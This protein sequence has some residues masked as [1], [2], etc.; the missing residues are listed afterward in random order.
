MKSILHPGQLILATLSQYIV[1]TGHPPTPGV[2]IAFKHST[3]NVLDAPAVNPC[4]NIPTNE[5]PPSLF[6][7]PPNIAEQAP[8]TVLFI[9]PAIKL[10]L[11]PRLMV[12]PYP[13]DMLLVSE[14]TAL[15]VPDII[16]LWL[17]FTHW[18]VPPPT[19]DAA[20]VLHTQL[21]APP[22]IAP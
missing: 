22:T 16:P 12:L 7:L 8:L 9:P 19:K 15:R 5:Q 14:Y 11:A 3:K 20:P 1:P 4:P 10:L 17:P 21:Y 18:K 13:P 2:L 6:P